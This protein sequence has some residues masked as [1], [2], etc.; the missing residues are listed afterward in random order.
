MKISGKQK[1]DLRVALKRNAFSTEF[2]EQCPV[3][4]DFTIER[5]DDLSIGADD[6][7]L[8]GIEIQYGQTGAADRDRP[9]DDAPDL[10]GAAIGYRGQHPAKGGSISR[11]VFE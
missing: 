9:V 6:R 2:G 3:V 8:A 10:I 11:A 4:E 7:L 5:D 1:I